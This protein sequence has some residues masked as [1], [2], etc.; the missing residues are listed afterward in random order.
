GAFGGGER[1]RSLFTLGIAVA[2][3]GTLRSAVIPFVWRNAS[4]PDLGPLELSGISDWA[5]GLV[6]EYE[7][8]RA[9]NEVLNVMGIALYALAL[10]RSWP[11][12]GPDPISALPAEDRER[13]W[14]A[15]L[16]RMS[17]GDRGL[18]LP[19]AGV[20]PLREPRA[21]A[22]MLGEQAAP[23]PPSP[24]APPAPVHEPGRAP[25][26]PAEPPPP[27]PADP[28]AP[29]EPPP[30]PGAP[31]REPGPPRKDPPTG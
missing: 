13:L 25:P 7:P 4:L 2:L 19:R 11:P 14:G 20:R 21:A 1:R 24:A 28:P 30:G 29:P 17:A 15:L 6:T 18:E 5:K 31:V 3:S 10:W 9:G 27:Q 23:E 12:D 16:A 8:V 22:L 26:G